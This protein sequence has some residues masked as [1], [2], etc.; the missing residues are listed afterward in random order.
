M[1]IYFICTNNFLFFTSMHFYRSKSR[2]RRLSESI[3][4]ETNNRSNPVIGQGDTLVGE[5]NILYEILLSPVILFLIF[6]L[7]LCYFIFSVLV[8]AKQKDNQAVSR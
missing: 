1:S 7:F 4:K 5:K 2:L 8:I 3:R 6:N